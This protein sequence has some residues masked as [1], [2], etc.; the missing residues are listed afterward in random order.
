MLQENYSM[1]L[2]KIYSPNR[3]SGVKLEK[4]IALSSARRDDSSPYL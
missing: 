4:H 1:P 2:D 3:Y